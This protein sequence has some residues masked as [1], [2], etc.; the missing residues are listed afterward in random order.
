MLPSRSFKVMEC[1]RRQKELQVVSRTDISYKLGKC[2]I[3]H[4]GIGVVRRVLLYEKVVAR[5]ALARVA[6]DRHKFSIPGLRRPRSQQC[7]IVDVVAP[8][9]VCLVSLLLADLHPV[10]SLGDKYEGMFPILGGLCMDETPQGCATALWEMHERQCT[11]A[12]FRVRGVGRILEDQRCDAAVSVD[13]RDDEGGNGEKGGNEGA[14][15][16]YN[17]EYGERYRIS[18]S[19]WLTLVR[20]LARLRLHLA[21]M[22]LCCAG[23]RYRY[24]GRGALCGVGRIRALV[25]AWRIF[26]QS[27][28]C[29]V[30]EF[31]SS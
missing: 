19:L 28:G 24:A 17:N 20:S 9:H 13:G 3:D 22:T 12:A 29:S 4:E 7:V 16:S 21:I 1:S 31:W 27:A 10:R 14:H 2:S 11:G 8:K 6:Q 18:P 25:H 15:L 26:F 5:Q 23:C 30:F